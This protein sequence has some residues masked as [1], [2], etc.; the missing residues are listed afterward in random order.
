MRA[1]RRLKLGATD[2]DDT[3]WMLIKHEFPVVPILSNSDQY[4]CVL[5]YIHGVY[6]IHTRC[7]LKIHPRYVST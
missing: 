4:S 7:M 1:S 3:Q 5:E 6:Q 2:S